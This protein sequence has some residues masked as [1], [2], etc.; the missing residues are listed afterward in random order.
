MGK[1]KKQISNCEKPCVI[2]NF[3]ASGKPRT[4]KRQPTGPGVRSESRRT[5][6]ANGVCNSS[7]KLSRYKPVKLCKG[8]PLAAT[9]ML[10]CEDGVAVFPFDKTRADGLRDSL[11]GHGYGWPVQCAGPDADRPDRYFHAA[12]GRVY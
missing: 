6:R 10:H 5:P 11:G 7:S 3:K 4:F 2:G 9:A 1:S 12:R 8:R